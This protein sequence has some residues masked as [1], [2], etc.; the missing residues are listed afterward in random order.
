[1]IVPDIENPDM[2][3]QMMFEAWPVVVAVFLSHGMVCFGCPIARFH[4]VIDACRDYGLD[5]ARF[6]T[7]LRTAISGRNDQDN[8]CR[9]SDP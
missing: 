9:R 2:P 1:M 5:E 4:N 3:L 7:D 6:R 8:V